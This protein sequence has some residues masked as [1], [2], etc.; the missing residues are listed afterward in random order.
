MMSDKYCPLKRITTAINE[1][2]VPGEYDCDN[3]SCAWWNHLSNECVI[4]TIAEIL[5]KGFA[6]EGA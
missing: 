3:E 5:K 1:Y 6:R 4:V 2:E